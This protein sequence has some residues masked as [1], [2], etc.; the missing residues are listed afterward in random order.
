[1]AAPLKVGD[2]VIYTD[3]NGVVY[4]GVKIATIH[5]EELPPYC[6]YWHPLLRKDVRA[7]CA[8]S[9]DSLAAAPLLP[10]NALSSSA[11]KSSAV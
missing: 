4:T 10:A 6:V 8:W 2:T 11:P 5:L 1:M 7:G 3:G 9:I